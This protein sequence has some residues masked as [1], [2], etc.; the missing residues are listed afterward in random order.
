MCSRCTYIFR[1]PDFSSSFTFIIPF[2][3]SPVETLKS[4]R[5]AIPKFLNVA[6]RPR[7][8]HGC[9]SSQTRERSS[10]RGR[11]KEIAGQQNREMER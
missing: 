9:N 5:N 1:F 7:P 11:R 8:S 4:S 10:R 6:Y 3:L 2:Q